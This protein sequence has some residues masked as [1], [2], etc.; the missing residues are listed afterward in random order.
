MVIE[1]AIYPQSILDELKSKKT[2]A[3]RRNSVHIPKFVFLCGESVKAETKSRNRN[4]IQHYFEHH[5]RGK[6]FPIFVEGL[7]QMTSAHDLLTYEQLLAEVCDHII[8]FMESYGTAAEL[9]SFASIQGII[10]KLIVVN[11]RKF[12]DSDSFITQ[13]PIR[14]IENKDCSNIVY[15][16]ME[17]PLESRHLNDVLKKII[18]ANKKCYINKDSSSVTISSYILEVL[19]II[20][21]LGPVKA[22][23]VVEIYKYIKECNDFNFSINAPGLN[24]SPLGE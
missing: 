8:L 2:E 20:S 12:R 6:V 22:N 16:S 15:C 21:V 5:A 9:G 13:G 18:K 17:T 1:R 10:D 4:M 23:Q 14:K 11:H 24:P 19:D 3:N 7:W